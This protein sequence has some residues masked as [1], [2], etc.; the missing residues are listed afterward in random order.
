MFQ[1]DRAGLSNVLE[2][3][4]HYQAGYQG[5]AFEPAKLLIHLAA[6]GKNFASLNG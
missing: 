2:R 1:A 4:R 5:W 3:L 6:S